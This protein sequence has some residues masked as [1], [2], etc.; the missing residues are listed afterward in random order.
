MDIELIRHVH[1]LRPLGRSRIVALNPS[2]PVETVLAE[3]KAMGYPVA[4]Q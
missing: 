1:A 2:A 3:A 4:A